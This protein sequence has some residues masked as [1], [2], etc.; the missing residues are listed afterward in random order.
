M[1]RT[2]TLL[3]VRLLR[4]HI[5]LLQRI[6]LRTKLWYSEGQSFTVM[7]NYRRWD[8]VA[9]RSSWFGSQQGCHSPL[10]IEHVHSL[11][12]IEY[13]VPQSSHA[14]HILFSVGQDI[15]HGVANREWNLP[16]HILLCV[17]ICHFFHSKQVIMLLSHCENNTFAVEIE[18]AIAHLWMRPHHC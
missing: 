10:L 15:C 1:Q 13:E 16:K 12:L 7:R 6:T 8:E 17:A 2:R 14:E 5:S 4:K 18:L 11:V 3:W 9:T